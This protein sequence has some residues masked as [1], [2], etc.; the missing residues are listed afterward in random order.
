MEVNSMDTKKTTRIFF[1]GLLAFAGITCTLGPSSVATAEELNFQTYG[2][3]ADFSARWWQWAFSLPA[4]NHPISGGDCE[5]GQVDDV[6]FLAGTF[7]SPAVR[8]CTVPAGKRLFFPVINSV[9]FKA[10]GGFAGGEQNTLLTMR[11]GAASFPDSAD[12][13]TCTVN[14]ETCDFHRVKSPAFSVLAQ[15]KEGLV[16]PGFL[17]VPAHTDQLVAD[18]FWVLLEPLENSGTIYFRVEDGDGNVLQEVTYNI[19]ID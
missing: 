5:Q 1:S 12:S 19:T 16:P 4:E 6:W 14:A 9:F 11:Q 15:Q 13:I 10:A 3:Y 18:G 2:T 17:K 7:S 8:D